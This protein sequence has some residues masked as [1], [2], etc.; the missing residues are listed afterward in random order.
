MK[1]DNR[2]DYYAVTTNKTLSRTH[3]IRTQNLNLLD[4]L[5]LRP[6]QQLRYVEINTAYVRVFNIVLPI[7]SLD[8][9]RS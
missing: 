3:F 9:P 7:L 1:V 5:N 4:N 6:S 2:R 8:F